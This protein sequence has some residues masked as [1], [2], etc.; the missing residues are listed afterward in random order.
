MDEEVSDVKSEIAESASERARDVVRDLGARIARLRSEKGWT[1]PD[2]ARRL[3]VS[4][5]RLSKWE[6]GKHE[7]PLDMVMALC[8][9]LEVSI[10]E[11]VTGSPAPEVAGYVELLQEAARIVMRIEP[12]LRRAGFLRDDEHDEQGEK[13]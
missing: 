3:E 7:P 8:D 11:L 10:D 4:R 12:L 5:E 13:P 9:V 2:L 6:R 1:Q